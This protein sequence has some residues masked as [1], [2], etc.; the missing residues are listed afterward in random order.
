M[1]TSVL[2]IT[3]AAL[4]GA[5]AFAQEAPKEP[6]APAPVVEKKEFRW[7]GRPGLQDLT[8]DQQKR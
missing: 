7:I 3:A 2:L 6:K 4:A 8:E 1:K 5:V